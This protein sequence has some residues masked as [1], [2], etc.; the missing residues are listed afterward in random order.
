MTDTTN[1]CYCYCDSDKIYCYEHH[2]FLQRFF[3][4]LFVGLLFACMCYCFLVCIYKNNNQQI[5]HIKQIKEIESTDEILPK[6]DE[7]N[8]I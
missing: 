5:K 7:L 2:Y 6:Y 4:V 1:R 8:K 3:S